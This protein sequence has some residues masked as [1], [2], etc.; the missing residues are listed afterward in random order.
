MAADGLGRGAGKRGRLM[1]GI[2]SAGPAPSE[3]DGP[4]NWVADFRR[5]TDEIRAAAAE[6]AVRWNEPEGRFIS[7][8]LGAIE[9]VGNLTASAQAAFEQTSREGHLAAEA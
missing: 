8:L 3:G 6:W 2:P 9:M 4:K 1:D 5:Q 7:A